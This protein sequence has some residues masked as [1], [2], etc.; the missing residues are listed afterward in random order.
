MRKFVKGSVPVVLLV[1]LTAALTAAQDERSDRPTEGLAAGG[2]GPKF[3]AFQQ[4][5]YVGGMANKAAILQSSRPGALQE[6]FVASVAAYLSDEGVKENVGEWKVVWGPVL[7][8]NEG[9]DVADNSMLV[10]HNPAVKFPRGERRDTYIVGIAGTNAPSAYDW[11]TEDLAVR[12]V[13]KFDEFRPFDEDPPAPTK[14]ESVDDTQPFIALGTATG[15]YRLAHLK[16]PSDLR[17]ANQNIA[18]FLKELKGVK[19]KDSTLIFT[20]H[21]L[22]GALSP[23]LA[24][25]LKTNLQAGPFDPMDPM[26]VYVYPTAGPTPGNGAFADAFAKEFP[27]D[28]T[29]GTK[30]HQVWNKMLWNSLDVVP[31]SW[32][33]GALRKVIR[34][35]GDRAP[36]GIPVAVDGAIK[37]SKESGI[38]YSRLQ[39]VRLTGTLHDPV[40]DANADPDATAASE[41]YRQLWERQAGWQHI[42]AYPVLL[43]LVPPDLPKVEENLPADVKRL[44]GP[45]I[46]AE[47][48]AHRPPPSQK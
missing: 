7:W 6:Q 40:P 42:G 14:T 20:G 43:G 2:S 29:G 15:V 22:A 44:K 39:N 13:V 32:E 21:S 17:G 45:E 36:A 47:I 30:P 26:K 34:I 27:P 8:Q 24:L 41:T 16:P 3:D 35:Y 31:H 19:G 38:T 25:W 1:V 28:R 23:T 18:E 12:K 48:K 33:T 4:A 46:K 11:F 5:F 10:L 9:S 37:K